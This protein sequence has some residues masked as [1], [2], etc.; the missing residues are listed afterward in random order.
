[1]RGG[2]TAPGGGGS[3][4]MDIWEAARSCVVKKAIDGVPGMKALLLDDVTSKIVSLVC[5]Q[6]EALSMQVYA[7]DKLDN[8]LR[9][10]IGGF[11]G[12]CFIR[13]TP[14]TI[15]VLCRELSDPKFESYHLFF[16]NSLP[17]HLLKDIAQADKKQVRCACMI[18]LR[19]GHARVA[20]RPS[21]LFV[22]RH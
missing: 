12:V 4:E 19:V 16:T 8:P 17:D 2:G 7:V 15:R 1:M 5:S 10:P 20:R 14:E 6:S 9:K 13:S 18:K 11:R 22:S 3:N 21:A